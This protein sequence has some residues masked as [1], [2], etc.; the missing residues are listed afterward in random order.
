MIGNHIISGPFAFEFA[1]LKMGETFGKI[2]TL[3]IFIVFNVEINVT[4]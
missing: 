4:K 2:K 1:I 3:G